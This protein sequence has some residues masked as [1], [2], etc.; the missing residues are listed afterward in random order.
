MR[1]GDWTAKLTSYQSGSFKCEG[2]R[3]RAER[4]DLNAGCMRLLPG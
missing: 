2:N 4:F 3:E 1:S